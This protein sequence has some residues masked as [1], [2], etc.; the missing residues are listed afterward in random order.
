MKK[1]KVLIVDDSALVRKLLTEI[2]SGDPEIEVVG[3]AADPLIARDKIKATNPDVLT[4]DVEMPKMDGLTFLANLMRLRPMPVVM[5]STL[6]EKGADVTLRAMELGA[7]DYISKPKL[8]GTY[9]LADYSEE[10][11]EKVKVASMARVK[12]VRASLASSPS[13]KE[14][15][16]SSAEMMHFKTTDKLVAIGA[17]TGGTEA[18]KHVLSQLP[19]NFP[20]IVISQ[21]I[22]P[23]FSTSFASSCNNISPLQV[24]EAKE[25]EQILPG[26]VYIA[27]GGKHLMIKR[28]GAR[29][30]C[31][32]DDG[33]A[34]NRFKPSV[35]VMFN[36]MA[37]TVAGNAVGVILTGMGVDGAKGLEAMREAGARTI[38]Q[39]QDSSVVW[40][41]PGA[42]FKAGAV[43]ELVPLNDVARTLASLLGHGGRL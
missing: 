3:T 38:G 1:I 5:V 40:G 8:G 16:V 42:A 31:H 4:L 23:A 10:I 36:S 13:I 19:A 14:G 12:A 43:Q 32:L 2:L 37:S 6:T 21:H 27:P 26:C 33:P 41:M 24:S 22:P 11:I 7:I 25:G 35:D 30:I 39:D 29:Y 15:M 28:S 17:S 34:V 9:R 18:I 20:A